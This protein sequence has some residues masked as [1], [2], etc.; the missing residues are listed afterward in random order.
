[1]TEIIKEIES[2]DCKLYLIYFE[3]VDV[4]ELVCISAGIDISDVFDYFENDLKYG[5]KVDKVRRIDT[6]P[7]NV[8]MLSEGLRK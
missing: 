7:C 2:F 8:L 4:P 3:G 5:L 6:F 1:M